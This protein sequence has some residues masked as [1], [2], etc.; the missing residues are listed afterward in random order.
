MRR[1]EP[2]A[3]ILVETLARGWQEEFGV[4]FRVQD[5]DRTGQQWRERR[6][7]SAFAIGQASKNC[8]LFLRDSFRHTPVVW[9]K[10][11]QW[12]LGTLAATP[13]GLRIGAGSVFTVEPAVPGAADRLILPGNRR[14][15]MFDFGRGV[16]RVQTKVGFST[17]GFNREIAV[18]GGDLSGPFPPITR[19]DVAAGWFEEP[20]L[21]AVALPRC[22]PGVDYRLVLEAV[23]AE[24]DAWSRPSFQTEEAGA[25]AEQLRN[26]FD[27]LCQ[28]IEARFN[29]LFTP[30]AA[31][32]T[33][34]IT[35]QAMT[36][37]TIVT[38]VGHGDLQAGNILVG[39]NGATVITDWEHSSRRFAAYDRLVALLGSRSPAGLG[40][41]LTRF[42]MAGKVEGSDPS[43]LAHAS[44]VGA[45]AM[46]VL[47]DLVW[48]A[49]ECLAGPFQIPS[50]GFLQ[51]VHELPAIAAALGEAHGDRK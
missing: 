51:Y 25:W 40:N 21:D 8:R 32:A 30:S 37:G 12:L 44:R 10:P 26:R 19:H 39:R 1:R 31:A 4:P 29:W 48:Y 9:R 5:G 11:A 14:V 33:R 46:L 17:T 43:N 50:A 27:T 20:V 35:R 49:E 2:F 16:V 45:A 47:E 6:P 3:S 38:S 42:V 13:T 18:R 22:P 23:L 36:G 15:R 34:L 41:R 7:F 24:L 28:G